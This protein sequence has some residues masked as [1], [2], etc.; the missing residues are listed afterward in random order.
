VVLVA[1]QLVSARRAVS[2]PCAN[3]PKHLVMQ[4][5]AAAAAADDDDCIPL[6]PSST[7]LTPHTTVPPATATCPAVPYAFL[8]TLQD[9]L[10]RLSDSLSCA[11]PGFYATG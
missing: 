8:R 4:L 11:L 9:L 1:Q 5:P 6:S 7:F 10:A 2:Q 3:C